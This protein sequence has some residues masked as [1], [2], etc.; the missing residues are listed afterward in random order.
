MIR[1]GACY[2]ARCAESRRF[3]GQPARPTLHTLMFSSPASAAIRLS[4]RT[5]SRFKFSSEAKN[6]SPLMLQILRNM[7][8]GSQCASGM[9]VWNS[10]GNQ[11]FG[12][13]MKIPLRATRHASARNFVCLSRLPTC[14]RTALEC[15][16][17][18]SRSGKGRSASIGGDVL[19]AGIHLLEERCVIHAAGADTVLVRIPGF[20]I[21]GVAVRLVAGCAKIQN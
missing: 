20:E 9:T 17:S 18:N 1:C 10:T 3:A 11:R 16:K 19:Q 7:R 8:G 5:E 14:S 6:S 15:T 12:V 4:S 2:F 13:V 21:I